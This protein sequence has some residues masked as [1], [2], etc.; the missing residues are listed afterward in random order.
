[1]TASLADALHV[2]YPPVGRICQDADGAL[3]VEA[4]EE[5]VLEADEGAVLEAE[6]QGVVVDDLTGGDC[7]E[8]A[9][10]VMQHL[11]PYT[12]IMNL[13]GLRRP[14][15]TPSIVCAEISPSVLY[16]CIGFALHASWL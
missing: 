2:F 14:L 10:R 6:A 8:E 4:D 15:L 7:D 5:A 11:V 3:A 16:K 9:Q 12:G 13:K 1:M